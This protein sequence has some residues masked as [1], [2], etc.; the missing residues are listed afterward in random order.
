MRWHIGQVTAVDVG[1]ARHTLR[2]SL[3]K[4]EQET[5]P[6]PSLVNFWDGVHLGSQFGYSFNRQGERVTDAAPGYLGA[7][8]AFAP[9][10]NPV[11]DA[12][13]YPCQ[14]RRALNR[15]SQGRL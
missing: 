12:Q 7:S 5:S 6:P 14:L 4:I 1:V 3:L 13:N 15:W 2:C 8:G 9:F 11:F 10:A